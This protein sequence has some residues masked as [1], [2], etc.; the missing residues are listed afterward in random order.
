M[1]FWL[2]ANDFVLFYID[3]WRIFMHF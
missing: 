3:F 2:T 1:Q